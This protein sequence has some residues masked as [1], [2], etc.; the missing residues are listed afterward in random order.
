[1]EEETGLP[2]KK[3]T[4]TVKTAK[5]Y[6]YYFKTTAASALVGKL[7]NHSAAN[8]G[9]DF[10]NQEAGGAKFYVVGPGS[11]HPSGVGVYAAGRAPRHYMAG[12]LETFSTPIQFPCGMKTVAPVLASYC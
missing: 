5:G 11:I 8:F 12:S 6:H 4:Y 7:V 1:V 10:Q 2:L 9:F 3:L